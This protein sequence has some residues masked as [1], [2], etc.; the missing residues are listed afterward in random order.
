[1][2]RRL[3]WLQGGEAVERIPYRFVYLLTGRNFFDPDNPA[4]YNEPNTA[5]ASISIA[6]PSFSFDDIY[7]VTTENTGNI[8]IET[9]TLESIVATITPALY[10]DNF[11]GLLA[12]NVVYLLR[13]SF[14]V[15][16]PSGTFGL[17]VTSTAE[18]IIQSPFVYQDSLST[19]GV[20]A[21][22]G[23]FRG[24]E[25]STPVAGAYMA[26]VNPAGS[27]ISGTARFVR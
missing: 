23:V 21:K 13:R 9:D 4:N 26:G 2:R 17:D 5:R 18:Q 1:M 7:D 24:D 8:T 20:E 11:T 6:N 14:T 25:P 10:S 3:A 22:S 15:D 27:T 16:L 12:T 19:L